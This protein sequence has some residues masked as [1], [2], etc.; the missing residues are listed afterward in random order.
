MSFL[1]TP[2]V[3]LQRRD[4][5]FEI[6]DDEPEMLHSILS[7][8]PKPLDLEG[9]I[10]NALQLLEK[11]PPEKLSTWGQIS[12]KSVLKTSRR[13]GPFKNKDKFKHPNLKQAERLLVH[14]AA[15]VERRRKMKEV[16]DQIVKY[17]PQA[18]RIGVTV[19]VGVSA[20]AL[21]VY[22]NKNGGTLG[23]S[24]LGKPLALVESVL[25]LFR[26]F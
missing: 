26:R 18:V 25:N 8:L 24:E 20:V 14:Q 13:A 16:Y 11:Y 23:W 2:K 3:V 15:E 22:I 6:P 4:E 10:A 1:N 5:L 7:K 21:G 9:L 19:A 17:K 12:S